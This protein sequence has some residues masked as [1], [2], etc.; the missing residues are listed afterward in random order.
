MLEFG[1][2]HA[3]GMC[4]VERYVRLGQLLAARGQEVIRGVRLQHQ[5]IPV[6]EPGLQ[7]VRED[8]VRERQLQQELLPGR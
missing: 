3:R 1:F 8:A 2:F 5:E 7:F 6:R 4:G